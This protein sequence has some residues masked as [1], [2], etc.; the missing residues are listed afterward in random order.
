MKFLTNLSTLVGSVV[1]I[2]HIL[3]QPNDPN[4]SVSPLDDFAS[5]PLMPDHSKKHKNAFLNDPNSRKKS[6]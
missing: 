2:L 3:I 1:L 5:V 6:F 4:D